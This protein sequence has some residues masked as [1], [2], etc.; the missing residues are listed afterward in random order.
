LHVSG[1]EC[2]YQEEPRGVE[3]GIVVPLEPVFSAIDSY[4]LPAPLIQREI[5]F[6]ALGPAEATLRTPQLARSGETP[7]RVREKKRNG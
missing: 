4:L 3:E 1:N 5:G 6:S 2:E 7:R